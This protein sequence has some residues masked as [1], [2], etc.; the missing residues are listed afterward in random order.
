MT[1][2]SQDFDQRLRD[3]ASRNGGAKAKRQ[4]FT[5]VPFNAITVSS[6]PTYLIKGIFPHAGMI[7]IWGPPKCGKSFWTFDAVM[8]IA[9]GWP[10][11]G[12]RVQKGAVVYLA[13][14]GGEGFRAR[15]EA[16]R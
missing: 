15:L 2:S 7:V 16:F 8:H 3:R 11:R 9:L 1:S 4:A 13:L 10:Y 5:L 6:S 12:R 14:E